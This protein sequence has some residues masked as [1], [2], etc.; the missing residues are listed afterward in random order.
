MKE[1]IKA[2]GKDFDVFGTYIEEFNLLDRTNNLRKVP[3]SNNEIKKRIL[4]SF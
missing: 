2:Q 1:I 4:F 3:L